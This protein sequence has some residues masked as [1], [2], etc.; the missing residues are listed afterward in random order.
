MAPAATKR[1]RGN[2]PK[3]KRKL[4]IG[5]ESRVIDLADREPGYRPA[6][7]PDY[8]HLLPLSELLITHLGVKAHTGKKVLGLYDT[9][10]E[11][12]G[13]EMA[14]LLDASEADLGKVL[15]KS[16]VRLL[17]R[18]RDGKLDVRPGYDGEYGVLRG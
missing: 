6:G 2:C 11:R 18:N 9:L 10:I 13:S 4:T 7:K 12:F 14:V 8:R 3:C 16:L 17:Q 1:M 5:V 15:D